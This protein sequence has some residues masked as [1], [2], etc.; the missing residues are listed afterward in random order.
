MVRPSAAGLATTQDSSSVA[1][2]LACQ[3]C[4]RNSH[5]SARSV[6]RLIVA[7]TEYEEVPPSVTVLQDR[8]PSSG[9]WG[10]VLPNDGVLLDHLS[11]AIVQA[12]PSDDEQRM[13]SRGEARRPPQQS[14]QWLRSPSGRWQYQNHTGQ[15]AC[16]IFSCLPPM[17]DLNTCLGHITTSHPISVLPLPQ[18]P[19]TSG[20]RLQSTDFISNQVKLGKKQL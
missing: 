12:S 9:V 19:S 1:G 6:A 10:Q 11:D 20:P 8:P 7:S 3:D 17:L 14:G 2:G 15:T 16:G 18:R 5:M 4:A 13:A